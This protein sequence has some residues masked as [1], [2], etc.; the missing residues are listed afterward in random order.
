MRIR[1]FVR[2]PASFLH[3]LDSISNWDIHTQ[4]NI[5][6][7][8]E[9]K[10]G[11]SKEDKKFIEKFIKIRKKYFWTK[12]DCDFYLSENLKAALKNCRK[13]MNKAEF[14]ELK[15]IINYFYKKI[16]ALF[17]DFEKDLIK[18]KKLLEIE[19]KKHNIR[20]M[21]KDI[22]KFYNVHK[23]PKQTNIHMIVNTSEGQSGG[24][25]NIEKHLNQNISLEPRM[26]NK[27]S[28]ENLFRDIGIIVHESLHLIG[29]LGKKNNVKKILKKDG[30]IEDDSDIVREAIADTLVPSGYFAVKYKLA[31]SPLVIIFKNFKITPKN[32]SER[33][34]YRDFRA[35]LAACLYPLT[36]K[37]INEGKNIFEGGYIKEAIKLF[38]QLKRR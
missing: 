8:Y 15:E 13:R 1:L 17:L 24:G 6:R 23:L 37:Q 25:A 27:R 9:K 22:A 28:K 20:K 10:F 31:K 4:G 18:R 16:H 33:H 35:K 34:Y 2:E 30:L 36:V 19:L 3:I 21:L 32:K 12:L 5:K 11:I 38:K 29:H 26:L 7:Y 14:S